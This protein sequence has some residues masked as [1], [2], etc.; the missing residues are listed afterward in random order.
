MELV[1]RSDLSIRAAE[2][3]TEYENVR[4]L[5]EATT[6]KNKKRRF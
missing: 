5:Y 2:I 6:K 1:W 4:H 3:N